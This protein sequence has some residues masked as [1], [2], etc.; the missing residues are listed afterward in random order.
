MDAANTL[1]YRIHDIENVVIRF[2]IILFDSFG[3][4]VL[5]STTIRSIMNYFHKDRQVRLMLAQGIALALEFKLAGEVLRIV[6][7]R[8]ID[9]LLILGTIILLRGAITLLIHWEIRVE[10]AA[11]DRERQY[12]MQLTAPATAS[13]SRPTS[14]SDDS[15]PTC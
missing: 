7:V 3:V 2:L 8:D 10:Q 12:E 11:E 4:V 9:E 6:M 14:V 1:L 13:Q 15:H 5:I